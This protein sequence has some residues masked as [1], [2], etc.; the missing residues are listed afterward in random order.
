MQKALLRQWMEVGNHALAS[1]KE[2]DEINARTTKRLTDQ[3]LTFTTSWFDAGIKQVISIT[4]S[5]AARDLFDAQIS[6]TT[7]YNK[8]VSEH[9]HKITEVIAESGAAL[10]AWFGKRVETLAKEA[11]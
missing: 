7:H 4:E 5:K 3:H 8:L 6:T 1:L 9:L 2:L 11:A 10:A